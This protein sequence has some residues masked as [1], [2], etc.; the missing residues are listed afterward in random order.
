MIIAKQRVLPNSL[1]DLD[2]DSPSI[3]SPMHHPPLSDHTDLS[4]LKSI[5]CCSLSHYTMRWRAPLGTGNMHHD[6]ELP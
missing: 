3:L 4:S 5:T 6:K 2:S 1:S